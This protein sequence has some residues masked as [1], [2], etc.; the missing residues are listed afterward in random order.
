MGHCESARPVVSA[1]DQSLA[2]NAGNAV[3]HRTAAQAAQILPQLAAKYLVGRTNPLQ[4]LFSVI[5]R[6]VLNTLMLP[7]RYP[8]VVRRARALQDGGHQLNVIAF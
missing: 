5:R 6:N 1:F 4:S 8:A 7:C 2:D 3:G